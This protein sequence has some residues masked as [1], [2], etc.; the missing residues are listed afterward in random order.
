VK[1]IP[2]RLLLLAIA[3]V[4]A[5]IVGL[6]AQTTERF[7]IDPAT[8]TIT[9]QAGKSGVFSF[10][11]HDHEIVAPV[12]DG[13]IALDRLDISRSRISIRFDAKSLKVTGRGEPAGD[14]AEV[15]Q[16]MLSDRVLDVQKYP[17]ISFTSRTMSVTKRS[18][19]RITVQVAGDLALHGVTRPLT[20]P[21]DVQ[22]AADQIRADGKAVVRQTEFGIEPVKAGGGTVR[23]KNEVEVSFSMVARRR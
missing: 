15:Q 2:G 23:V 6:T 4:A 22:L 8:S 1:I 16:V 3:T 17:V 21:V 5:G 7:A 19:D 18:G 14:V 12:S 10:A 9:L 13:E 20:L 11:G